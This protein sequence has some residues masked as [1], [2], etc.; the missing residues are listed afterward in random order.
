MDS[1]SLELWDAIISFL[2]TRALC[3]AAAVSR[4]WR[5]MAER[6]L[7]RRF[8]ARSQNPLWLRDHFYLL[9]RYPATEDL[10]NLVARR[11][12]RAGAFELLG[13]LTNVD[14]IVAVLCAA[15]E[16][17]QVEFFKR[18]FMT[19]SRMHIG[20]LLKLITAATQRDNLEI[21]CIVQRMLSAA[22]PEAQPFIKHHVNRARHVGYAYGGNLAALRREQD[23]AWH[24]ILQ[25]A[26]YANQVELVA[27]CL[28]KVVSQDEIESALCIAAASDAIEVMHLLVTSFSLDGVTAVSS[29]IL[30][31][32]RQCFRALHFL[33]GEFFYHMGDTQLRDAA[34]LAVA[35]GNA[36]AL[37]ALRPYLRH[38]NIP[39]G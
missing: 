32:S 18:V 16:F 33:M 4:T 23:V 29:T 14:N 5:Y 9:K 28:D 10:P 39:L 27:Y 35:Q 12:V 36:G 20:H 17:K 24:E 15:I 31:S 8:D 34:Q 30:A 13:P 38:K 11:V 21:L 22:P 7:R 1:L 37:E 2:P 25:C 26:A 19:Q 6:Y 3:R